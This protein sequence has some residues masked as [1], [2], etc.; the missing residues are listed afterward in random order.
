M[1]IQS[2]HASWY[3]IGFMIII[4]IIN[5]YEWYYNF[6][7]CILCGARCVSLHLSI[8]IQCIRRPFILTNFSVEI[9]YSFGRLINFPQSKQ[10]IVQ[11]MQTNLHSFLCSFG[12]FSLFVHIRYYCTREYVLDLSKYYLRMSRVFFHLLL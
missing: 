4:T 11:F 9:L 5:T 3:D 12:S 10:A 2:A 6:K 8:Y 1:Q 7:G